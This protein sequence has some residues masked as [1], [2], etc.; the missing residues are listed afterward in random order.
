MNID[1]AQLLLIIIIYYV[2]NIIVC[3]GEIISEPI[4]HQAARLLQPGVVD[5]FHRQSRQSFSDI[6]QYHPNISSSYID[7]HPP[8]QEYIKVN[9]PQGTFKAYRP[10]IFL[11]LRNHIGISESTYIK[12]LEPSNLICLSS[13]SKSG[14]AFWKTCDNNFV[15]KTIKH[16]ECKN[17]IRILDSFA[18]H[19][20]TGNSCISLILGIYRVRLKSGKTKYFMIAKNVYSLNSYASKYDLKGS[21]VGRRAKITSDVK[22]DLDLIDSGGILQLGYSKPIVMNA[23]IRDSNFLSKH[24]FMDYSLLVAIE[25]PSSSHYRRFMN[26]VIEPISKSLNDRLVVYFHV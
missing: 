20:L 4:S 22:K 19:M 11:K 25:K 10:D 24:R 8:V 1:V 26:R 16:Y 12:S 23:L 17:L 9:T 13:D 21:T 14:S 5:I 6:K 2:S 3:D 7:T 15:L 18:Y